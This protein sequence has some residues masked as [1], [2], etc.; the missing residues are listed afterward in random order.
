MLELTIAPIVWRQTDPLP[1]PYRVLARLPRGPVAEFPFYGRRFEFHEHTLYMMRSTEHWQPLL[2]GYSDNIPQD[3][4][5]LA[6][7]LATFP[8]P[9]AFQAMRERRVRYITIDRRL[10][11]ESAAEIDVRLQPFIPYLRLLAADERT[12][13][14]EVIGFPP[15]S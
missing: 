2:N 3:F 15:G 12:T 10:Y 5:T 13:L 4:R 8:S 6:A 11:G 14:Y 9:E 1:A 7:T